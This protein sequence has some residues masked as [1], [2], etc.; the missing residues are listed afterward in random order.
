[1][2]IRLTEKAADRVRR[3]LENEGGIGLR[4]GVKRTG[5][6]GWAYIVELANSVSEQDTVFEDRGIKI[7]VAGDSLG[8]LDGSEVDFGN[9]G[10]GRSFRF[11]NPNVAAQCGCG[12][13]FTVA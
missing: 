2:A 7:I 12:E 1:M 4:L 13:S 8:L 9:E 3:F 10:L 5:C 6:S 11:T